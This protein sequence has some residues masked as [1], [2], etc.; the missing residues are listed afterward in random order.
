MNAPRGAAGDATAQA[1]LAARLRSRLSAVARSGGLPL[2][3]ASMFGG[4][5]FMLDE[6]LIAS[7]G[8]AG[9]LLVRVARDRHDELLSR[10]GASQPRMGG[11]TM[12]PGWLTVDGATLRDDAELDAWLAEALA[13]HRAAGE[14]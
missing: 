8:R 4:R 2:R 9:D 12:G 3:E 10:P 11:R 14:A 13:H 1:A 5:A 7:A 6:R